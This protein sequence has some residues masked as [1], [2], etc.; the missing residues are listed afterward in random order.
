MA[1][2]STVQVIKCKI[3]NT[4]ETAEVFLSSLKV[5]NSLESGQDNKPYNYML[6]NIMRS[7]MVLI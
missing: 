5:I 4:S 7:L 3:T 6:A 2:C 1:A